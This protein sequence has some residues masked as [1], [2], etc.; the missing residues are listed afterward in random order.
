MEKERLE[1]L[2]IILERDYGKKFSNLEATEIGNSLIRYYD[3]LLQ[4][5]WRLEKN[6]KGKKL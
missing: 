5:K 1:Q 2:K 6:D 3:T 4:C